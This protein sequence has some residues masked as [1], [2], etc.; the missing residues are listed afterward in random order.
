MCLSRQVFLRS[1]KPFLSI[2]CWIHMLGASYTLSHLIFTTT[3]GLN[4]S[5]HCTDVEKYGPEVMHLPQVFRDT[6]SQR[7]FDLTS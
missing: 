3:P 4:C 2:V 6:E 1:K 5:P 7:V